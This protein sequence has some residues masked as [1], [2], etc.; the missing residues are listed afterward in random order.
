MEN[1]NK[2]KGEYSF[3]TEGHGGIKILFNT[4]P[5][6]FVKKKLKSHKFN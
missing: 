1:N 5:N 6:D 4:R 3:G 2:K